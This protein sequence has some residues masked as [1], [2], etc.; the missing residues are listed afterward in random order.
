MQNKHLNID[1][2]CILHLVHEIPNEL[3]H[4]NWF[5]TIIQVPLQSTILVVDLQDILVG[6]YLSR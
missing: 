6:F 4:L 5:E 1:L 2:A 3:L